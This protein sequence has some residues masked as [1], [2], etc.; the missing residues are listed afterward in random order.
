MTAVISAEYVGRSVRRRRSTENVYLFP[1]TPL[2]CPEFRITNER[3]SAKR[4]TRHS[5]FFKTAFASILLTE[6]VEKS[7]QQTRR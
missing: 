7:W 2:K 1:V 6:G 5:G 3:M 4:N